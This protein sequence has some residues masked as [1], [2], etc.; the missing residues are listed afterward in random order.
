MT[1]DDGARPAPVGGVFVC[2][3]PVGCKDWCDALV[4]LGLAG[5][6]RAWADVFRSHAAAATT[7]AERAWCLAEAASFDRLAAEAEAEER[8]ANASGG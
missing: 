7:D 1:D 2:R 3:P 5:S 6:R 4:T 8:G